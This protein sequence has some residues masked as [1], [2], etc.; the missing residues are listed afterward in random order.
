M[1]ATANGRRKAAG[2]A[3]ILDGVMLVADEVDRVDV[4]DVRRLAPERWIKVAIDDP[5]P[6]RIDPAEPRESGCHR[7]TKQRGRSKRLWHRRCGGGLPIDLDNRKK[8]AN[9][10][11]DSLHRAQKP[12]MPRGVKFD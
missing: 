10:F 6:S 7:W 12:V 1:L 8:L 5:Q 4:A 9:R 3:P 2:A 11:A